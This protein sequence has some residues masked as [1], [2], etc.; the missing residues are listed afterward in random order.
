MTDNC[1]DINSLFRY[2]ENTLDIVDNDLKSLLESVNSS[3]MVDSLTLKACLTEYF[4]NN[5]LNVE[6]VGLS[7]FTLYKIDSHKYLILFTDSNKYS[8]DQLKINV[9]NDV[10]DTSVISEYD[11]IL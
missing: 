3:R 10:Q 5:Q 4:K 8:F 2:T 1:F 7:L 9:L 11:L 6:I